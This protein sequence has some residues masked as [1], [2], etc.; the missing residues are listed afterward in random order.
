MAR[1]V[2]PS[3]STRNASRRAIHCSSCR[4]YGWSESIFF[5]LSRGEKLTRY[6]HEQLFSCI[7]VKTREADRLRDIS[8]ITVKTGMGGR[9]GNKGAILSRSFPSFPLAIPIFELTIP[10]FARL[11]DR[12]YI[13][14]LHQ[15]SSR[16]WALSLSTTKPR[17]SRHSRRQSIILEPRII[18]FR[19]LLSWRKRHQRL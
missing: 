19:C 8:L 2:S 9:Y 15:R 6:H 17:S 1:Q 4:R 3:S 18:L 14:L 11:R 10:A 5:A 13:T 7:F 12:R 16:R